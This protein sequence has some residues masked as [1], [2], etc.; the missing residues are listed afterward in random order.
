MTLNN[1]TKS[2]SHNETWSDFVMKSMFKYYL[3]MTL[4]FVL[5]IPPFSCTTA[6]RRRR[7]S[8][9]H[10]ARNTLCYL[11]RENIQFVEPDMWPPSPDLN[12]VDDAV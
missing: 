9:M 3:T 5:N 7:H 2:Q 1:G 4:F 10:T 6:S 8:P 12:P 11:Q